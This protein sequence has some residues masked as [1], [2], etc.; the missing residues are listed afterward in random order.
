MSQPLL[1]LARLWD[2]E[3]V[4][5]GDGLSRR[6]LSHPQVVD[7]VFAG[8]V[9]ALGKIE[10]G[11]FGGALSLVEEAP[12]AAWWLEGLEPARDAE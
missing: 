1:I 8:A 9:A 11:G 6:A 12:G 7:A 3:Q 10:Y 5:H 4:E 2:P